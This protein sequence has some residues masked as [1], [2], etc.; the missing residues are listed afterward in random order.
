VSEAE[1]LPRGA[2]RVRTALLELGLPGEIHRLADSTRTAPEAAAAVGCELGAIVK[3]LVM[4]GV[5]SRA[6]V[7]A[8][9][10]GDNRADV[11]LI[12]AA[13]DEPV[14]RPDAQYVRDVT[15]YAIGGIPPV[16]HPD[17]V[18]TVM[19]EDLLRFETVWAAAGHPHAV[20]PIAPAELAKAADALVLPLA[21][22]S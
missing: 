16:G 15:G 3:S 7:L 1:T 21:E 18:R 5:T 11:T 19:D 20:F 2:R 6:P 8:L 14:E 4:R 17:R 9:V 10:S 22:R 12:E 13:V